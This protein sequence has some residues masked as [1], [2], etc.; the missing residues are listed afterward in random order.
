MNIQVV[1]PWTVHTLKMESESSSETI[2]IRHGHTP[3]RLN[4]Q[5][6]T[7]KLIATH[8]IVS[9]DSSVGMAY[10]YGL[11]GSGS[12]GDEIFPTRSDWPWGQPSLLYNGYSGRGV[13]LTTHPHL[14]L[15]L[16]K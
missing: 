14:A 4:L 9:R 3:D 12:N 6:E 2:Y 13:V 11:D 15:R 5:V 7:S 1:K 10:R 16:K 8:A